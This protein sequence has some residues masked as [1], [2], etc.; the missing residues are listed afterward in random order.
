M[1]LLLIAVA[2]V[3]G[4]GLAG[5]LVRY[6]LAGRATDDHPVCRAC[7][8][9]LFNLPADRIACPECGS[10]LRTPRAVRVGNRT[11]RPAPLYAGL[12]L[13]LL[14]ALA[15]GLVGTHVARGLD[16]YR[17]LPDAWVERDTRSPLRSKQTRAWVELNR[18]FLD[19]G[20]SA[21]RTARLADAAL[22]RQA[23]AKTAWIKE[24]GDFVESVRTAGALPRDKWVRYAKQA[25]QMS[26]RARPRVGRGDPIVPEVVEDGRRVGTNSVLLA[27]LVDVDARGDLVVER[28]TPEQVENMCEQMGTGSWRYQVEVEE[29]RAAMKAAP[30]G[31]HSVEVAATVEVLEGSEMDPQN[32]KPVFRER[33]NVKADFE[34][35]ERPGAAIEIIADRPELR[36][37]VEAAI[38][39]NHAQ[40]FGNSGVIFVRYGVTGLPVSVAFTV[41]V[42]QGGHEWKGKLACEATVN[43]SGGFF[44]PAKEFGGDRLDVIFDP[45]VNVALDTVDATSMWNGRLEYRDVPIERPGTGRPT[46]RP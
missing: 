28:D 26:A 12:A 27:R 35:V 39:V 24:I 41:T 13:L 22:A 10:D 38:K 45:D 33:F 11:R 17:L 21:G 15:A 40:V 31:K 4:F 9:D 7:R 23:D 18:R 6:G 30:A 32:A 34:L 1:R 19:N 42:R 43:I 14:C 37:Q 46:T 20:L 44:V 29:D 3:A 2:I 36:K 25:I 16:T 5:A 8:F